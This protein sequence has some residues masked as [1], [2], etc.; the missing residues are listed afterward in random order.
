VKITGEVKVGLLTL[1]SGLILYFGFNFLKGI[2]FFDSTTTY[3]V[4]YDEVG[5]L[6]ASNP[7]YVNGLSVGKVASIKIM[8]D[9]GNKLLVA[10]D[11]QREL[12]FNDSSLASLG[13]DGL[14]GG[15]KIDLIVQ[16]GKRVLVNGDTLNPQKVASLTDMLTARAT[17]VMATLDQTLASLNSLLKEYEGMSI[18]VKKILANT[19]QVTTNAN[20]IM[21]DNRGQLATTMANVNRLTN[22]LVETERSLKPILGKMNTFADSLN[23]L[24][25]AATVANA[26]R[27]VGSLNQTLAAINKG[28]GSMG[29]FI[30]ND[31]LYANIN[32]TVVSLDSLFYDLKARPKR[33]VH[34]SLFG[35]RDRK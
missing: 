32:R 28:Q 12:I 1:V 10:M 23:S 2:E 21:T 7:V 33:Y 6:K 30:Y 17:P 22:S 31:S 25:L 5:G 3:Y 4:V 18:E 16:S 11:V 27:T 14:L 19:S 20:G 15:K 9:R 13:D 35:R 24:Q 8:Q 26:N 34:F 29:K